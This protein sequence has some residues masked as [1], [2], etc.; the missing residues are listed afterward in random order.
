VPKQANDPASIAVVTSAA[1]KPEALVDQYD[2]GPVLEAYNDGTPAVEGVQPAAPAAPA[3]AAPPRAANGRFLSPEE[4]A[5]AA[6][7][8]PATPAGT[9]HQHSRYF[10]RK[11]A[12]LGISQ[13]VVNAKTPDELQDLIADLEADHARRV[14]EERTNEVLLHNDTRTPAERAA[15]APLP[16]PRDLD[17]VDLGV[18]AE[19]MQDGF[20]G[21]LTSTLKGLKKE[22]RETREQLAEMVRRDQARASDTNAAHIDRTF[23]KLGPKW[24]AIIGEGD[25][26]AMQ[27]ASPEFKR[28]C[29]IVADARKAAGPKATVEQICARIPA[30]ANDLY[31]TFIPADDAPAPA[32][33]VASPAAP[34]RHG[35][36]LRSSARG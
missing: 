7:A 9:V 33:R 23:A 15:G 35:V 29:A 8:A 3:A 27:Q 12:D 30:A 32:G 5:A 14:A 1:P 28:R 25:V 20:I 18:D 24:A 6:P 22:L 2:L 4:A 34:A 19:D 10:L 21:N 11:A 16:R 36:D 17:D 13:A 31:G 26:G